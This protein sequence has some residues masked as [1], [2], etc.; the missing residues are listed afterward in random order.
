MGIPQASVNIIH[1]LYSQTSWRVRVY[2][3]LF[4]IFHAKSC[5]YQGCLLSP[6][7]FSIVID[8]TM[9]RTPE[10]FQNLGVQIASNKYFVDRKYENDIYLIF[11]EKE[12][13]QIF[14]GELT[15]VIQS[16]GIQMLLFLCILEKIMLCSKNGQ[17]WPSAFTLCM[18]ITDF[19]DF[20]DVET[21]LS[22]W[23]ERAAV[24]ESQLCGA[25]DL[26][27]TEYIDDILWGYVHLQGVTRDN[28]IWYFLDEIRHIP[29]YGVR[30]F[31]GMTCRNEPAELGVSRNG[32]TIMTLEPQ[33]RTTA[34]LKTEFVLLSEPNLHQTGTSIEEC[35]QHQKLRWLGHVLRM[36]NHRLPNR[37]L[38][39]MP[40]S[41][42][43]KQRSGQPLTWQ[44][45]MKEITKRLGA[46]GA[47]HL[48]GWAPRDPHFV[49]LEKLQDMAVNRCQWRSCYQSNC[50][51]VARLR[52]LVAMPTE[53]GT[54]VGILPGCPSLDRSSR[55]AEFRFERRTSRWEHI[56]D[57]TY[58]R[59]TFTIQMLKKN[60][61]VHFLFEDNENARYLWQFCIQMHSSY[62]DYWTR[63]KS[64]PQQPAIHISEP[65]DILRGTELRYT[66]PD[67]PLL[68]ELY[69][70]GSN[71]SLVPNLL[72]LS[73]IPDPNRD[74]CGSNPSAQNLQQRQNFYPTSQGLLHP[75]GSAEQNAE[76]LSEM[77]Q[78]EDGA[79]GR[80]PFRIDLS[81]TKS[82]TMNV[83]LGGPSQGMNN[84]QKDELNLAILSAIREGT[85][86]SETGTLV[87]QWSLRS[88]A[89]TLDS[90]MINQGCVTC[91]PGRDWLRPAGWFQPRAGVS[92]NGLG[93]TKTKSRPS[94]ENTPGKLDERKPHTTK[95][96]KSHHHRRHHQP[97]PQSVKRPENTERSH[98]NHSERHHRHPDLG[99]LEDHKPRAA[100]TSH[101]RESVAL[102]L[103]GVSGS[104]LI[105]AAP[106]SP[107]SLV[108]SDSSS[109]H[110]LVTSRASFS[111]SSSSCSEPPKKPTVAC[112]SGDESCSSTSSS[113]SSINSN[114]EGEEFDENGTKKTTFRFPAALCSAT[115]NM[116]Y[117]PNSKAPLTVVS[118]SAPT[119]SMI[120]GSASRKLWPPNVFPLRP[121]LAG[122][123][124]H[125]Y[126]PQ[127]EMKRQQ[128][129]V[130]AI[131]NEQNQMDTVGNQSLHKAGPTTFGKS[132]GGRDH[133]V[134][135]NKP[136]YEFQ[137]WLSEAKHRLPTVWSH[138]V[139]GRGMTLQISPPVGSES[140]PGKTND[141]QMNN[142]AS[143]A[144]MAQALS[145]IQ[146]GGSHQLSVLPTVQP[147]RI[148]RSSSE[149]CARQLSELHRIRLGD[150]SNY[151]IN[152][153]PPAIIYP[154]IPIGL[155]AGKNNSGSM[156][157]VNTCNITPAI[158]L[159]PPSPTQ[160][161]FSQ[162]SPSPPSDSTVPDPPWPSKVGVD[163]NRP[164][165][166]A[167]SSKSRRELHSPQDRFPAKS[168]TL[169]H[170]EM[171]SLSTP[172]E[173]EH[174]DGQLMSSAS[175]LQRSSPLQRQGAFRASPGWRLFPCPLKLNDAHRLAVTPPRQCPEKLVDGSEQ[176]FGRYRIPTG[177]ES[178]GSSSPSQ[179]FDSV[180]NSG[181]GPV[182]KRSA[183]DHIW[184]KNDLEKVAH[185]SDSPTNGHSS[186]P[187]T[188]P[189]ER[190]HFV[191]D[192][193]C[194]P[195]NSS[196]VIKQ[197][198]DQLNAAISEW[199]RSARPSAGINL[200][201][202]LATQPTDVMRPDVTTESRST[203]ETPLGV[204][205]SQNI[206]DQALDES[207]HT[208]DSVQPLSSVLTTSSSSEQSSSQRPP[209]NGPL[210]LLTHS[211]IHQLLS[212]TNIKET[213]LAHRLLA[214]YRLALLQQQTLHTNSVS[215]PNLTASQELQM[216]SSSTAAEE[217]EE[218]EETCEQTM[219]AAES[220]ER[221]IKQRHHKSSKKSSK[222]A[223]N[224]EEDTQPHLPQHRQ[225]RHHHSHRRQ[226]S[227]RS[228]SKIHGDD[229]GVSD[230]N[231][232]R[233]LTT[234]KQPE[235]TLVDSPDYVNAA[236]FRNEQRGCT[237][238]PL[239][240]AS[241]TD[242]ESNGTFRVLSSMDTRTSSGAGCSVGNL[243]GP[244]LSFCSMEGAN[245][246]I[247][248]SNSNTNVMLDAFIP[249][250]LIWDPMAQ[251]KLDLV[252][253]S[254]GGRIIG[255][256]PE[257][258][259]SITQQ[260]T[261][262][263]GRSPPDLCMEIMQAGLH[264][265]R[266]DNQSQLSPVSNDLPFYAP[267][268][269]GSKRSSPGEYENLENLS[270]KNLEFLRLGQT[271]QTKT[272]SRPTQTN[273]PAYG[274]SFEL[275]G[276][277]QCSDSAHGSKKFTPGTTTHG[278]LSTLAY[279]TT[280]A[281]HS[282]S[283]SSRDSSALSSSSSTSSVSSSSR[284]LSELPHTMGRGTDSSQMQN[285]MELKAVR[286][287]PVP[288][289]HKHTEHRHSGEQHSAGCTFPCSNETDLQL[290]AA[291]C[292]SKA[293]KTSSTMSR[294]A[295]REHHQCGCSCHGKSPP[296]TLIKSNSLRMNSPK[297]NSS[298]T[299][300]MLSPCERVFARQK[301]RSFDPFS[302]TS[303]ARASN[304]YRTPVQLV[305]YLSTSQTIR[306]CRKSAK[307]LQAYLRG[308][309]LRRSKSRGVLA[310]SA[311]TSEQGARL[312]YSDD[313]AT[314]MDVCCLSDSEGNYHG[315]HTSAT[316]SPAES[317]LLS[318]ASSYS[319]ST[320]SLDV[321]AEEF[322]ALHNH[323]PHLRPLPL[324]RSHH[325][326]H[327]PWC[328]NSYNKVQTHRPERNR[329]GVSLDP[330]VSSANI[331]GSLPKRA[332][333]V[334][335][336]VRGS[337][338]KGNS[339]Q[340]N[341]VLPSVICPY[342]HVYESRVCNACESFSKTSVACRLPRHHRHHYN[343]TQQPNSTK[344]KVTGSPRI[345]QRTKQTQK[346]GL[347]KVTLPVASTQPARRHHHQLAEK[348]NK[349]EQSSVGKPPVARRTSTD[350]PEG[351]Q[352]DISSVTRQGKESPT[353]CSVVQDT[354]VKPLRPK[355]LSFF[356][357]KPMEDRQGNGCKVKTSP[358][359]T[360]K[361]PGDVNDVKDL[362]QKEHVPN[363]TDKQ[364]PSSDW[365]HIGQK[366]S[367]A[368]PD[369]LNQPSMKHSPGERQTFVPSSYSIPA[370]PACTTRTFPSS[371][372]HPVQ[373]RNLNHLK[374]IGPI[375]ND[376][377]L[378][379]LEKT[380]P[381]VENRSAGKTSASG[382]LVS[383]VTSR[384]VQTLYPSPSLLSPVSPTVTCTKS[385]SGD[386]THKLT[387]DTTCD[388]GGKNNAQSKS[389]T[390]FFIKPYATEP[391]CD[392]K[393]PRSGSLEPTDLG[394]QRPSV[395]QGGQSNSS[396]PGWSSSPRSG[397]GIPESR[398]HIRPVS[399]LISK[400]SQNASG[401]SFGTRTSSHRMS[402][403][404]SEGN[405]NQRS[406]TPFHT[407]PP[408]PT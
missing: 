69:P 403:S 77:L 101:A 227:R 161:P 352:S 350:P 205:S 353:K 108:S 191:W 282:P 362:N 84:T 26:S 28:A 347:R 185:E 233:S 167:A 364:K 230:G 33:Q 207:H 356:P 336:M 143:T 127:V 195:S 8:E 372:M 72:G 19:G 140:Q 367:P 24:S 317:P 397:S 304:R 331:V 57:L 220:E 295:H 345:H 274:S 259:E 54:R 181:A 374:T 311:V 136:L 210:H 309:R 121:L 253:S 354:P 156:T 6:L 370:N 76:F 386:S 135:S 279:S 256:V 61:A 58:S 359:V 334:S 1:P 179:Q 246:S 383:N 62:I 92:N 240:L 51:A 75:R 201:H 245:V 183:L 399:S 43:R 232:E 145:S 280:S 288:H 226:S 112:D 284:S 71:S 96:A 209:S 137:R 335:L 307:G 219:P 197:G 59:K 87:G 129:A 3:E 80:R 192:D 22:N 154:D 16:S 2:G 170:A 168:Q 162:H 176:V 128:A 52:R 193:L 305:P 273:Q 255:P 12:K 237:D 332:S 199:D 275:R 297:T 292:C 37:V 132:V 159:Y 270:E 224:H 123:N 384:T 186:A 234:N 388:T 363:R 42:W 217:I 376:R 228:T 88:G 56:K 177:I 258:N 395:S 243:S 138:T 91:L 241:S 29:R 366:A 380:S 111:S 98:R 46:V 369:L 229:V 102:P 64:S 175:S 184:P 133:K 344:E 7:L 322:Y 393:L 171:S 323:H 114:P 314:E 396:R 316:L 377:G 15:K 321:A 358:N 357:Q 119:R 341:R 296:K 73:Q 95:R 194:L 299:D 387:G 125:H 262:W 160:T 144:S 157:Q 286:H 30:T 81:Y 134:R 283:S 289:S 165:G 212:L 271:A 32:V 390:K 78:S 34:N 368:S 153:K 97:Q 260:T 272:E 152:S 50:S 400:F 381:G 290:V 147:G 303:L 247:D 130:D 308:W 163:E 13:A 326:M 401:T 63:V 14:S 178:K 338:R 55:D 391:G 196:Q 155:G 40:N 4:K 225:K 104:V 406:P 18:D 294:L 124:Q 27:S 86:E 180:Q 250:N 285:R 39:S 189:S 21:T 318:S 343:Q 337:H 287:S 131:I 150:A 293:Y 141:M 218:V 67:S 68:Q 342:K 44:R 355:E 249:S 394:T 115:Q 301:A 214:E 203:Q 360:L 11:V 38:F 300:L 371:E 208:L 139:A 312:S 188:T 324:R 174:S 277:I 158:H 330:S 239:S 106:S 213:E 151:V 379:L 31:R 242:M 327:S 268:S 9:R 340:T 365:K 405:G 36:P 385:L 126:R 375:T 103:R 267:R 109:D 339:E 206:E 328:V 182:F 118:T 17:F 325:R 169:Q 105:G 261:D 48:P 265:S 329:R 204:L 53:G 25:F 269:R 254:N 149:A 190:L 276:D 404:P 110:G 306:T 298:R 278:S 251:R 83:L 235:H 348:S 113:T 398:Y 319:F 47:T 302:S 20:V 117:K 172:P 148:A 94:A 70:D 41:E 310:K 215:T 408:G 65:P 333:P 74:I 93:S 35:V 257:V 10:G 82:P 236:A 222:Q 361:A 99:P 5:F 320:S 45:S 244:G 216:F 291:Q 79:D 266:P 264:H 116:S 402:N 351:I 90:Q 100:S 202:F 346:S 120:T 231:H 382:A 60:K 166:T 248:G 142:Q 221:K 313:D 389:V 392:S 349:R 238:R 122:F 378:Y 107:S 200:S 373:Q 164:C 263:V 187:P 66:N 223:V 23:R 89:D 211:D 146:P 49:W 315:N 252:R 198:V 407:I 281:P 85:A 173:K